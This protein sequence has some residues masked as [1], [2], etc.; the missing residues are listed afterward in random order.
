MSQPILDQTTDL[1]GQEQ[2]RLCQLFEAPEF[3]K[4][5]STEQRCG[6][7]ELSAHLYADPQKRLYPMHSKSAAWLSAAFFF[8]KRAELPQRRADQIEAKLL[9]AATFWGIEV[10]VAGLKKRADE[11]AHDDLAKLPDEDFCWV[12]GRERHLPLRNAAETKAAAV[13]LAQYRDE[14]AFPDRQ[15]MAR[16]ILQKAARYGAG[17]GEHDEFLER[18]AGFGGCSAAQAA[19]LVRDRATI[20]RG[21]DPELATELEKMAELILRDPQKSRQP[22]SLA[23]VAATIDQLD[24][25]LHIR[26]YSEAVPRAEDVLFTI[27]RKTAAAIADQ[28]LSMTTGSVYDRDDLAGLRTRDVRRYLGDELA[29]AVDG[30]G[31]HV[32]GIKLAEVIPTLPLPDARTFDQLCSDVG[33]RRFT[34]EAGARSGLSR[35]DWRALANTHRP[36]GNS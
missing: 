22:T 21:K 6:P 29:N 26:E 13:Y 10:Q 25:M 15:R 24:R 7:E 28:H 20:V 12:V 34:K 30:D 35:F 32:D 3:V 27:T 11:M 16:K 19:K 8:E 14:F 36:G 17:L 9:E 1:N 23:K 31:I 5:A 2:Y 4:T 33:I 18:V